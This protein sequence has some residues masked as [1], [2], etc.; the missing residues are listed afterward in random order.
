MKLKRCLLCSITAGGYVCFS[1]T[2]QIFSLCSVIS[3]RVCV[4]VAVCSFSFSSLH[5]PYII[6][7]E[8]HRAYITFSS[9]Y[10]KLWVLLIYLFY[11]PF[12][13]KYLLYMFIL[14][15]IFLK[16]IIFS[17]PLFQINVYSSFQIKQVKKKKTHSKNNNKYMQYSTNIT[18]FMIIS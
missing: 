17:S 18:H 6:Y 3:L 13:L 11:F 1:F 5:F 9:F 4:F 10:K 12:L 7:D 15:I 16:N 2:F 14:C 8:K